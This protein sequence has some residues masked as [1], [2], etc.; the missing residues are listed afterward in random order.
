MLAPQKQLREGKEKKGE[1]LNQVDLIRLCWCEG[2]ETTNQIR[3][4]SHLF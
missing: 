3:L 1:D 4:D 2:M